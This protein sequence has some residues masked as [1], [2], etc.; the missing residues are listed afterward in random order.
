MEKEVKSKII[1]S[2]NDELPGQRK[3]LAVVYARQIY[4]HA[5]NKYV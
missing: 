3:M 4:T 1:A 2:S 5:V